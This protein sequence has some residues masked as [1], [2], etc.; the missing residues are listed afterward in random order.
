[1]IHRAVDPLDIAIVVDRD[2]AS[3]PI[4]DRVIPRVR[5]LLARSRVT[6]R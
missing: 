5:R 6:P 1:M 4:D 3:A 2:D